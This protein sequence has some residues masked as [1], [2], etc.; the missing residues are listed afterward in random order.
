MAAN[1]IKQI[2]VSGQR[3]PVAKTSLAK[4][5]TGSLYEPDYLQTGKSRIPLLSTINVQIKGY[6][7]PILESY[8]AFVHKLADIIGID[9]ENGWPLPPEEFKIQRYKTGTNKISSE[10]HLKIYERNT[11]MS[12]VSSLKCS[13]LIRA[14]EAALP[15]GVTLKVDVFDPA[16][17][18]KR[19]V[20]DKEL[21]DLQ[22]SLDTLKT[23]KK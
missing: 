19:Y 4:L 13:V 18:E 16:L 9:V 8:Q 3:S 10:F 23:K 17:E 7:Y 5:Y 22:T 20:P 21:L 15:Q 11:Q 12:E 2:V 6:D 1:L 14:L